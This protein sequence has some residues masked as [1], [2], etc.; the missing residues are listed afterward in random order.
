MPLTPSDCKT[1]FYGHLTD[2]LMNLTWEVAMSKTDSNLCQVCRH[3]T[4]SG[5][6][7]ACCYISLNFWTVTDQEGVVV[8]KVSITKD[9]TAGTVGVQISHGSARD[10]LRIGYGSV[11]DRRWIGHRSGTDQ[12]WIGCVG[13]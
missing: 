1:P 3:S 6:G 11:M 13:E 5:V 4:R 8:S 9:K 2:N 10:R 7:G 12:V